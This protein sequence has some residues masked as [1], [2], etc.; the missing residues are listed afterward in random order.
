[1]RSF[2]ATLALATTFV[3][4]GPIETAPI[5]RQVDALGLPD[6]TPLPVKSGETKSAW[7]GSIVDLLAADAWAECSWKSGGAPI[8]QDDVDKRYADPYLQKIWSLMASAK[9]TPTAVAGPTAWFTQRTNPTCNVDGSTGAPAAAPLSRAAI[10]EDV[11]GTGAVNAYASLNV[12]FAAINLCIAQRMREFVPGAVG[13]EALLLSAPDQ[14]ELLQTVRE[15][16][17]VAMLHYAALGLAFATPLTAPPSGWT[18]PKPQSHV[19]TIVAWAQQPAQAATLR[20][21]GNDFATAV[22]A[23]IAVSRELVELLSRSASANKPRGGSPTSQSEEA[24][25]PASFRHRLLAALYGGDPLVMEPSGPWIHTLGKTDPGYEPFLVAPNHRV[26]WPTPFELPWQDQEILSP[27]TWTLDALARQYDQIFLFTTTPITTTP[28]S[29]CV[30]VDEPASAT[31]LYRAIEA[32]I[33]T[34]DCDVLGAGGTCSV[35]APEDV[36]EPGGDY[37]AYQLWKKHRIAPT[38]AVA[39]THYWAKNVGQYCYSSRFGYWYGNYDRRATVDLDGALDARLASGRVA[40]HVDPKTR[41]VMKG[42]DQIAPMFAALWPLYMPKKIDPYATNRTQ[43]LSRLWVE[44]A[45]LRRVGIVQALNGVRAAILDSGDA[46]AGLPSVARPGVANYFANAG[47]ILDAVDAAVGSKSAVLTPFVQSVP[48]GSARTVEQ[49]IDGAEPRWTKEVLVPADDTWFTGRVRLVALPM[50]PGGANMV[51]FPKTVLLANGTAPMN[52]AALLSSPDVRRSVFL[53]GPTRPATTGL[54]RNLATWR[55]EVTLPTDVVEWTFALERVTETTDYRL[56]LG[57]ARAYP[58]TGGQT[59]W[60]VFLSKDGVFNRL[61]EQVMAVRESNPAVPGYDAFGFRTDWVPPMDA[62]LVGGR[63]GDDAMV[64]YLDHARSAATEATNAVRTAFDNLLQEKGDLAARQA[65]AVKS[66]EVGKIEQRALCGDAGSGGKV[67]DTSTKLTTIDTPVGPF[68]A[69]CDNPFTPP[70]P[71][72]QLDC[73]AVALLSTLNIEPALGTPVYATRDDALQPSFATYKGGTL[74]SIYIEQWAALRGAV[75]SGSEL[76]AS[77]NA[78]KAR[79]AAAKAALVAASSRVTL[80]C[81]VDAMTNAAIAG[82]SVSAGLSPSASFSAGPLIAQRQKC[83]ELKIELGPA[84]ANALSTFLDALATVGAQATRL[85]DNTRRLQESSARG[86]KVA[87]DAQL[88]TDRATL[89]GQ[90][91]TIGLKTSFGLY[92]QVTNFD[93]WRARALLENARRFGLTARRAVEGRYVVELRSL[94]GTEPFVNGPA[95]WANEVYDY[96]LNMPAAVGLSVAK[97]DTPGIYP[98]RVLDYVGNLD[99]FVKGYA[100]ARPSAV[101]QKDADIVSL[102][103]AL[104][105]S[106]PVGLPEGTIDAGAAKWLFLCPT[107]WVGLGSA[108]S[109]DTLCAGAKPARARLVFR[110]D[111]W[112]RVEGSIASEPFKRRYNARFHRLAV[113]L[114]GTG[115]LDC[116]LSSDPLTCYSQPFVRYDLTQVGPAWVTNYEQ[117]W[118]ALAIGATRVEGAKGLAAERFLD[119]LAESFTK[120]YVDATTRFELTDRPVGG[121]Y[122]IELLVGPEVQ[123]NRIE[124]VQVLMETTYWAKAL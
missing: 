91:T 19:S 23:H 94:Y 16:A 36:P 117:E 124:R 111:P 92:R 65:A 77:V 38:D 8:L 20:D 83:D 62:S 25:G 115:V 96:D 3:A 102:P 118:R 52:L 58:S 120:P 28:S 89:E 21:M 53:T 1:M 82:M 49:R 45:D 80:N 59:H 61:A 88:A 79:A 55:F 7:Q 99:R 15:R 106:S 31:R 30:P 119:P 78:A 109:A 98:N 84:R 11:G 10:K 33:R 107:G 73:M 108:T 112:G 41:P 68:K 4:C 50:H 69:S 2:F 46:Y 24:W 74:Q 66:A 95:S 103:G 72:K 48:T 81:S 22:N 13:G 90:L 42:T 104:G 26:T 63:A 40:Y 37:T 85:A 35:V 60:G 51:L 47:R 39:L 123:L 54:R 43:Q 114:V 116:R 44:D 105:A 86:L 6:I 5:A 113:N 76:A 75:L 87:A 101:A 71:E 122:Q 97:A 9:C 121:A 14:V 12:E 29:F 67:C 110:L 93:A 27:Q 34:A 64:L 17:Q 56:L 18:G 70:S 100:V 57:G 32:S